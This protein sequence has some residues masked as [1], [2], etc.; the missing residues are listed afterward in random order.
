MKKF[1]ACILLFLNLFMDNI[2]VFANLLRPLVSVIIPV[3]NTHEYLSECLNSVVNQTLKDIE[4]ILVDDGSTDGSLELLEKYQIKDPRVILITQQNKG[5][6]SARNRGLDI[7]RGEYIAF[8]DSDDTIDTDAYEISYRQAK[9]ANADIL[10]FA[11]KKLSVKE[12][13]FYNPLEI[14]KSVS[15]IPVW[16]KL[17]KREFLNKCGAKFYEEAKCFN[18]DCFNTVV[19]PNAKVIKCIPNK[20]YTYRRRREG[21]I[22]T[23]KGAKEKAEGALVYENYVKNNLQKNNYSINYR[24]L[25]D[26]R[27]KKL[28]SRYK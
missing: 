3:Y 8:L 9:A 6:S 24:L 16:N 25:L 10:M 19:I 15:Y 12:G 5:A 22:Q 27:I 11:E 18:D 1:V 14:L 2:P 13:T 21:S 17:Y 28:K 7:A 23:S 4:I 26:Q 20:F